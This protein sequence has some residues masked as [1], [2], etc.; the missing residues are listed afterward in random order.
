MTRLFIENKE[1]DITQNFSQQI[2]YAVDDLQNMDS[3]ATS[4]TK[5]IV[6]PGTA[7]NNR[8]LGNIF[9]FGNANFTIDSQPNVGYNFNAAKSAQARIEVDGLPVMKGVIRLLEILIDEDYIEYEVA[10]FGELGGLFFSLGAAKLEQLDFSVYNHSLTITEIEDSWDNAN[11]GQGYYYPLIDYGNCSPIANANF[12][13]K[14]WYLRSSRPA[15]FVREY[16]DKIIT[17]AGYTWE[18]EFMDTDY[19]KSLMIPNN[20]SRLKFNRGTIS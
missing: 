6:L 16:M 2:T 13:K 12:A 7:N 15:L 17:G 20:Q 18:S 1:L 14:N 5:T 9:E 10:L 19:F 11:A 3:K 4:F 8:L